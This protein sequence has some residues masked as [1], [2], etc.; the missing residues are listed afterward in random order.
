MSEKGVIWEQTVDDGKFVCKVVD[1]EHE[2]GKG[3][4]LCR[5]A[6]TK[7]IILITTVSLSYGAIFGPDIADVVSWQNLCITAIDYY[8]ETHPVS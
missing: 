1:L 5:V 6:S 8:L 4:L 7:E 2:P 3:V